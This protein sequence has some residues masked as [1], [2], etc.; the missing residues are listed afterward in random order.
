MS[1][2]GYGENGELMVGFREFYVWRPNIARSAVLQV[3][4]ML[5]HRPDDVEQEVQLLA[6]A[7]LFDPIAFESEGRF[8]ELLHS[9]LGWSDEHVAS[10]IAQMDAPT[11]EKSTES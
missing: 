8:R 1:A 10:L 7:V 9:A 5:L 6:S 11:D 2:G 3:C 4:A